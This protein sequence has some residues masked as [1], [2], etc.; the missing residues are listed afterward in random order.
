[1][2]VKLDNRQIIKYHQFFDYWL[3]YN[4]FI[5]LDVLTLVIKILRY[6]HRA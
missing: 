1:M 5:N 2:L 6:K 4:R 3:R